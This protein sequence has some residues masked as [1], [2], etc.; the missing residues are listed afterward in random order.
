MDLQVIFWTALY[1]KNC[2]PII[3]SD[4]LNS[5]KQSVFLDA[6][7]PQRELEDFY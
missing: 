1:F 6:R 4:P 2:E 7:L 3:P 5:A